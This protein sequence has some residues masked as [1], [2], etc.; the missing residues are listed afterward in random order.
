MASGSEDAS[1]IED[2]SDE[3]GGEDA[4][5]ESWGEDASGCFFGLDFDMGSP[6]CIRQL[7]ADAKNRLDWAVTKHTT[8]DRCLL[9]REY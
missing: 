5:G 1:G 3:S 8:N 4:S 9:I 7:F 6:L 2:A